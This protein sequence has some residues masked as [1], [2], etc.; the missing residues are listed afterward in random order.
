MRGNRGGTLTRK[1]F[2]LRGDRGMRE[3]DMR[4]EPDWLNFLS[5][6]CS[7]RSTKVHS[8]SSL[9]RSRERST[10]QLREANIRSTAAEIQEPLGQLA[11]LTSDKRSVKQEGRRDLE[12]V[13]SRVSIG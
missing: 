12:L 11:N 10:L 2:C 6:S 8:S 9:L 4:L 3:A 7:R 5:K 1:R 13:V